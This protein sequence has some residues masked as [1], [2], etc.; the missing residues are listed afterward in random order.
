MDRLPKSRNGRIAVGCGA[1][2]V[3]LMFCGTCSSLTGN[4]AP[5]PT[6][7]AEIKKLLDV[8]DA[9]ET[10]RAEPTDTEEPT[11][12]P[13]EE[14]TEAPAPTEAPPTAAPPTAVPQPAFAFDPDP[15]ADQNCDDFIG[16]G[17]DPQ[18]W[19]AAHQTSERRNPGRLDGDG[20]GVVCEEGEGGRAA[21]PPP[22]PPAPAQTGCINVNTASFEELKQIIH[23]E[24]D[25]AQ[26]IIAQRAI[27][28]FR[29]F[30]DLRARIDG[31]GEARIKDIQ[32]QGITCF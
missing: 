17:T 27:R 2:I 32:A 15:D 16:T 13:T 31:I 22:P 4:N 11:V 6:A 12:A 1:V 9:T 26:Q 30:S 8:P 29:G 3:A 10:T 14:A 18:A 20:D 7:T 5:E 23:I 24:D 28:P 21:A 25:R 19:W